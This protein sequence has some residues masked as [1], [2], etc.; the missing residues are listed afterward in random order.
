MSF[1][2]DNYLD[3]LKSIILVPV[4]LLSCL[5]LTLAFYGLWLCLWDA[6]Y[7]MIYLSDVFSN[8][9]DFKLGMIVGGTA[10][11]LGAWLGITMPINMHRPNKN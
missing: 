10:T 4:F 7:L 6:Y 5:L 1:R 8:M 2:Q 9:S 11:F 3:Y